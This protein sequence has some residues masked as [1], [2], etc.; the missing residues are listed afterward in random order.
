MEKETGKKTEAVEAEVVEAGGNLTRR[1]GGTEIALATALTAAYR[2]AEDSRGGFIRAAVAFGVE[3]IRAEVSLVT[4]VTKLNNLSKRGRNGEGRPNSGLEAWLAKNCPTVNYATAKS[5][6]AMAA[7]VIAMLSSDGYER[8]AVVAALAAPT[9]LQI[10]YTPRFNDEGPIEAPRCETVP[11]KLIRA[12][13]ALFTEATSRRKLEQMWF[14]FAGGS[15]GRPKGTG[16]GGEDGGPVRKLSR[17]EEAKF[18]WNR[19]LQETA[20]R[21]VKDAVPLLGEAETRVAYDTLGDV[22]ALLKRHLDEFAGGA[23]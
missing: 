18:I 4:A 16:A 3:L 5:Y 20:K 2:R 17:A 9:E 15:A 21:S 19:L 1:D 7:R 22:R 14:D 23:R 8:A 6:K 12:R 11:A 10:S 13:E